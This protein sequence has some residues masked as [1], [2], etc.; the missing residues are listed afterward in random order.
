LQLRI[1]DP[2]SIG[3]LTSAKGTN[4]E[5]YLLMKLARAGLKTN[6][7]DNVARLCHASTVVGLGY[8]LGSGATTNSIK[9]LT[10]AD[11]ILVAGSNTTDQHP[12]VVPY[13]QEA[14]SKGAKLIVVDP[15]KDP[16]SKVGR[17]TPLAKVGDG[18]SLDKRYA[19]HHHPGRAN[20]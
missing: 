3:V 5:N 2:K 6:N 4:E 17:Y 18:Y 12:L 15:R 19:E 20:R 8:A 1:T 11:V 7:V 14:M 9:S 10:Q 16:Y 13:I